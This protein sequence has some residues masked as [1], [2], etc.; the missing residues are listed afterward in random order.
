[1]AYDTK[2]R[3]KVLNFIT[4]GN[5]IQK[6]HEVFEVGTTAIREWKKLNP[7]T[8]KLE[9]R[10]LNRKPKKICLNQLEAYYITN[11][12]SY[13]EEAAKVFNCTKQAI[14]YALKRLKLQRKK[15]G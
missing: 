5:S 6:A 12:D 9:K 13:M 10:P 1:M 4:K 2:F 15:N 8:A 7:E 14:F 3:E 11:P